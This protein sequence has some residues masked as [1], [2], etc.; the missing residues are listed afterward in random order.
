MGS[1]CAKEVQEPV[2]A[3]IE[4]AFVPR[5]FSIQRLAA[6]WQCSDSTVKRL[7]EDGQLRFIRVR[8]SYRVLRSSVLDYEKRNE[9]EIY[10]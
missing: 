5:F 10:L 7:I 2:R 6:R 3:A 4:S 1:M 8:K 9:E